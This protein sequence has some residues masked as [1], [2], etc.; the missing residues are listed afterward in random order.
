MPRFFEEQEAK[1]TSNAGQ[2]ALHPLANAPAGLALLEA[3]LHNE[4]LNS[5]LDSLRFAIALT[6]N[7]G[8]A[9]TTPQA[10]TVVDDAT[11]LSDSGQS[12]LHPPANNGAAAP[13]VEALEAP[14]QQT[15]NVVDD[16]NAITGFVPQ[17]FR[18]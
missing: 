3:I 18:R 7:S 2:S 1:T 16:V 11:I 6:D 17:Y 13:I 9:P 10:P 15:P 12:A 8:A 4:A 14:A 5:G